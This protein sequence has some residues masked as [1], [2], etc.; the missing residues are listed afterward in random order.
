MCHSEQR[1]E[2]DL[3]LVVPSA[4]RDLRAV[5]NRVGLKTVRSFPLLCGDKAGTSA[6]HGFRMTTV[7]AA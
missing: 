4:V 2:S 3:L 7:D 1:E 6:V 5:I